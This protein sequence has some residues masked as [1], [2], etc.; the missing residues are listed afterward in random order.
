MTRADYSRMGR[1]HSQRGEYVKHNSAGEPVVLQGSIERETDKAIF[2]T[3]ADGSK[4]HWLPKSQILETTRVGEV[5]KDTIK[6]SA[7]I[8]KEKGIKG[9]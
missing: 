1:K 5:G 7:W 9:D 4:S 2:F 6:I 3:L 8:A